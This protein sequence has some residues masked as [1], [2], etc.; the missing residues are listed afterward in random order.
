MPGAG[1]RWARFLAG[2]AMVLLFSFGVLPALQRLRPVRE[3]RDAIGRAHIDATGLFY[4]DTEVFGEA[5][6]SIRNA[7]GYSP[8]SL[9][10]RKEMEGS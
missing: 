5:E 2:L 9:E 3:V 4:T 6:A 8:G 1:R 7:L 10:S